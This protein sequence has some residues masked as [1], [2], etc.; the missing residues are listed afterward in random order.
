MSDCILTFFGNGE[1]GPLYGKTCMGTRPECI[2]HT[3][4]MNNFGSLFNKGNT[5]V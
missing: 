5:L 4:L 2:P 1:E 3:L